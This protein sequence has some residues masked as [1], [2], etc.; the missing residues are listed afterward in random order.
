MPE[1][2][3]NESASIF[4]KGESVSIVCRVDVPYTVRGF[5]LYKSNNERSLQQI[6][7]QNGSSSVSFQTVVNETD[8]YRCAYWTIMARRL[9]D[10]E[11]SVSVSVPVL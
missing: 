9:I 11:T 3:L 4:L 5:Y 7:E 2:K 6:R 8:E 10:S 1:I